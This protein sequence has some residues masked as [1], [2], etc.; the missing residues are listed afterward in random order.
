MRQ[1]QSSFN[2]SKSL[3][4]MPK[5]K[6]LN[7]AQGPRRVHFATNLNANL[8]STQAKNAYLTTMRPVNFTQSQSSRALLDNPSKVL[9]EQQK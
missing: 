2:K 7:S 9:S 5:K 3:K 8:G 1:T 4:V 6:D